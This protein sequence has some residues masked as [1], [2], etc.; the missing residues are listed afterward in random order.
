MTRVIGIDPGLTGAI[1]LLAPYQVLE[2][3]QLPV[4][5]NGQTTGS[6]KKWLDT[7]ALWVL[8]TKWRARHDLYGE[9]VHTVI[10][11]PIPMPTLPAQT[12]AS[13]FDTFGALRGMA[14]RFSDEIFIVSPN[15][16]K[17]FYG[18]GRDKDDSRLHAQKMYPASAE[19]FKLKNSHNKAEAL[20]I[21]HW[22]WRREFS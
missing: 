19:R 11:R 21:A 16:W 5:E 4:C 8:M 1:C 20:L 9:S 14:T 2:C 3:E 13:Q 15:E 10:E 17:K 12:I 6:M 22:F 18:L 7:D